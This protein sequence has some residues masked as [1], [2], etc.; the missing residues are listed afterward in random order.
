MAEKYKKKKKRDRKRDAA[1]ASL[2]LLPEWRKLASF[3]VV[4]FNAATATIAALKQIGFVLE[5]H[6]IHF[7]GGVELFRFE[8]VFFFHSS[9]RGL[10]AVEC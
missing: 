6:Y 10:A 9:F 8:N 3:R 1:D 5:F 4:A 7:R 2:E